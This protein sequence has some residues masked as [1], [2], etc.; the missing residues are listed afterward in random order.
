MV[1]GPDEIDS[2]ASSDQRMATEVPASVR[3]LRSQLAERQAEEVGRVSEPATVRAAR[4]DSRLRE[5]VAHACTHSVWHRPR[6]AAADLNTLSGDD[7]SGLP[8]MTKTDVME[9]WDSIVCDPA[10]TLE[11]VN[12][13]LDKMA[14]VGPSLLD[15]RYLPMATGGSTGTRGVFVWDLADLATHM[16]ACGRWGSWNAAHRRPLSGTPVRAAVWGANAVHLG[17]TLAWLMGNEIRSAGTPIPDLVEWLNE[18]QPDMLGAYS[19][20]LS[21]L[22][23]EAIAGR[24]R[25]EPFAVSAVAEPVDDLLH[26]RVREAWQT[27]LANVYSLTES[28]G[29]AS[30]FLGHPALT[31]TDD[32][33]IIE[34]VDDA[35]QPVPN[36]V[37]GDK[38]FLTVL[39]NRTIP[40]VR[41]EVTDQLALLPVGADDRP[42]TGQLISPPAGRS[43]D[44]FRWPGGIELHPHVVRSALAQDTAVIEYQV[45]QTANGL[46]LAVV[47]SGDVD[48][49]ALTRR[50][51]AEL[52]TIGLR[53]AVVDV[54]AVASLPRHARS[55]K[56]R[57]FVP[58]GVEVPRQHEG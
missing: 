37:E 25:I 3:W 55:A 36:G 15:D 43:D 27:G 7:L 46:D 9:N 17:S 1:S 26:T 57:R 12:V 21:R 50:L 32:V 6:L 48:T 8:T 24:L 4:R 16:A 22:A 28:P 23:D 30:S 14:E 34:V 11:R 53:A 38:I 18:L 2:M 10:L 33:A 20:V 49:G 54:R 45:H 58:L 51:S 29:M 13:H 52:D 42:W 47:A 56:L 5:L 39:T 41:Y 35:G 31:V 44:W 40:L 19:S